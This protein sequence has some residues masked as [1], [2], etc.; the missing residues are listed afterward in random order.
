MIEL[1]DFNIE[2]APRSENEMTYGDALLYCAFC[3]HNGY[4]NWRLPNAD[5]YY[6]ALDGYSSWYLGDDFDGICFVIP[7]RDVNFVIP[8]R[9]V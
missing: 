3:Q 4:R 6:F 2:A 7:V 8:V 9:D 1:A 5:E